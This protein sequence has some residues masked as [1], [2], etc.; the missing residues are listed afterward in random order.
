MELYLLL[1]IAITLIVVFIYRSRST[2]KIDGFTIVH[3]DGSR[4]NVPPQN[5][6]MPQSQ[7]MTF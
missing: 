3:E 7:N 6:D 4:I 2:N 5:D 1:A